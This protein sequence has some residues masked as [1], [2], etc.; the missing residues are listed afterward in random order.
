MTEA[1]PDR[2]KNPTDVDKLEGYNPNRPRI[3]PTKQPGQI[4]TSLQPGV[5]TT[6][7]LKTRGLTSRGLTTRGSNNQGAYN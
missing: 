3:S 6:R 5:L 7:G 1:F 2:E 4:N